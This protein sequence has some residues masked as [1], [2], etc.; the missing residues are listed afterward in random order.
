MLLAFL[1]RHVSHEEAED[2]LQEVFVRAA[3]SVHLAELRNPG[4]YLCRIAQT[5]IIDHARR[6]NCRIS[7]SPL[8]G[9]HE[10]VC[11]PQ[12]EDTLLV[13]ALEEELRRGL[14]RLPRKTRSVFMLHRYHCLT[15]R[16]IHTRLGISEATVEYHMVK[17]LGYLRKVLADV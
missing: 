5:V 8:E 15:Y 9:I 4:G 10:P 14:L 16:Q 7:F 12:Q 11:E 17:A 6:R 3:G 13:T 2:F 1:R